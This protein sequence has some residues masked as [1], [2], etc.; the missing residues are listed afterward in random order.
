[1]R[2]VS[3][4][5]FLLAACSSEA[6]PPI[7]QPYLDT[8]HIDW[9]TPQDAV[10]GMGN[11]YSATA[12]STDVCGLRKTSKGCYEQYRPRPCGPMNHDGVCTQTQTPV[13]VL[14]DGT[15]IEANTARGLEL[16]AQ[17]EKRS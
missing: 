2:V 12:V 4:F 15:I 11:T 17:A 5:L 14:K 13:C 6:P 1:M 16:C 9:C 7:L 10:C 3:I 8:Q